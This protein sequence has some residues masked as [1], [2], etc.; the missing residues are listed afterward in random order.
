[1]N[2]NV[3]SQQDILH[4]VNYYLDEKDNKNIILDF[5]K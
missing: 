1:M 5:Q 4:E 2:K 3:P